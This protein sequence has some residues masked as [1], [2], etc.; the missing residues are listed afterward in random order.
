MIVPHL[1]FSHLIADYLLQTNWLAERKGRFDLRSIRSWDGLLLHGSMVW[2]VSLAVL[3]EYIGILWPYITL[4]A[5]VHTLQDAA[6]P[7]VSPR[8]NVSPFLAYLGDQLL[9]LSLV[10]VFQALVGGL[11]SPPPNPQVSRL[12]WVGAALIAVMRFYEV[13]WWAN[14]PAM[15]P[16]MNRWRLWGYTERISM[17]VLASAGLWWLA[18]FAVIPRVVAMRRQGQPIDRQQNGL[19]ELLLGILFSVILGLAFH[20]GW[21]GS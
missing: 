18:P 5:L 20:I 8:L 10:L 7:S 6:K 11:I 21:A 9:H 3:P 17:L 16:Y 14:W 4:L 15:Y 1:I 13:S 19:A 12:M 2:L